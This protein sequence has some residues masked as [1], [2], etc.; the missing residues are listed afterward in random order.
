[1]KKKIFR[2]MSVLVVLSLMLSVFAGCKNNE[3][4]V[5]EDGELPYVKLKCYVVGDM[6][7]GSDEVLANLNSMLKEK[8][9]AELEIIEL[10]W[11]DYKSKYSLVL[12]SGEPIDLIYT[13]NWCYF[14]S[15]GKKGAFTPLS[16]EMIKKYAP[17]TYA[18]V[19]SEAWNY[20]KIDGEI[21][22]LPQ[23]HRA[24]T[25]RAITYR[26]DLR[27]KYNVPEIK[28]FEDLEVYFDAIKK[29]EPTMFPF[30]ANVSDME[31]LYYAYTWQEEGYRPTS[32]SDA[33]ATSGSSYDDITI[34]PIYEVESYKKWANIA[35]KWYEKGFW[36]KDILSNKT[37]AENAFLSG[38]S[39][40]FVSQLTSTVYSQNKALRDNP[41]WEL[42]Q[43][44]LL[45]NGKTH[46]NG[47]T[48]NGMAIPS[49]SKNVERAL[50]AY[51]LLST[52]KDFYVAHAYGIEGKTYE[53][54]PEGYYVYP[55]GYVSGK[56]YQFNGL[57]LQMGM[58][59][60]NYNNDD[61]SA[62]H[63][64]YREYVADPEAPTKYG[65]DVVGTYIPFDTGNFANELS[66]LSNIVKNV[67]NLIITGAGTDSVDAQIA[68]YKSEAEKAG[69]KTIIDDANKQ[70]DEFAKSIKK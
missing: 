44:L 31:N 45:N 34:K 43:L 60:L 42:G 14:Y 24:M 13:S 64:L 69:I 70:K 51:D 67:N 16:E 35:K 57:K 8:I 68:K 53:V 56:G 9:N 36:S 50:M 18:E 47:Y 30:H 41:D 22:M 38:T 23:H 32:I 40:A 33:I 7:I 37:T 19:P 48:A 15:E 3:T 62:A 1:M 6:S 49:T 12:S 28:N 66:I 39:A 63:E 21:C 59:N 4:N 54:S 58:N 25:T 27:K 29:N 11:S 65:V 17:N 46:V 2:L 20:V 61:I 26:E 55:E 10:S 5:G 52:D